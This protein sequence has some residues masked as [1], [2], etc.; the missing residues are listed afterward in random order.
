MYFNLNTPLDWVSMSET[1][2][3]SSSKKQPCG[4]TMSVWVLLGFSS[5]SSQSCWWFYFST[6]AVYTGSTSS[7]LPEAPVF[8][9]LKAPE[10]PLSSA[11]PNI[12]VLLDHLDNLGV[13]YGGKIGVI[14]S[15]NV[16]KTIIK[17]ADWRAPLHKA[18]QNRNGKEVWERINK[19]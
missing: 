5:S 7:N 16:W 9:L 13:F 17:L 19:F 18:P 11:E 14:S 8:Q 2:S 10:L 15:F 6:V 3:T 1:T 12:M 4:T